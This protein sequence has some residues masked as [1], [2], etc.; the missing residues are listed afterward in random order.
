LPER[1]IA[2]LRGI[3][4]GK[5]KRIAMADLRRLFEDLGHRDVRTVLN[6]GN[7]IYTVAGKGSAG[8]APRLEKEIAA[9]FGVT[10]RVAVLTADELEEAVNGDPL[11]KIADN[12]SRYLLIAVRDA[13]AMAALKP[14]LKQRWAPESLA[15]GKRVAYLWCANGIMDSDLWEAV[16]KILGDRGTARNMATM[17]R[18]LSVC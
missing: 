11:T 2:F 5:A 8:D 12:P 6:S 17:T 7:V 15:L 3:N 13:E 14:L 18:I 16:E 4:V 9:R 1:R 10:S